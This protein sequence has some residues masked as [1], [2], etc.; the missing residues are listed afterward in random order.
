MPSKHV[1]SRKT[2]LALAV[3]ALM[4]VLGTG[5]LAAQPVGTASCPFAG[6]ANVA[7]ANGFYVTAYPGTNLAQVTLAFR[8]GVAETYGITLTAHRNSY[9]GPIIG[10]PRTATVDLPATGELRVTFDFGG[11]P[12]TAGDTIAFTQDFAIYGPDGAELFYD[13]GT[14][15]C[16]SGSV[17][18]T[19]GTSPPLGSSPT[20]GVGVAITQLPQ[21]FQT[22]I[23][24]DTVL[25]LDGQ[26]GDHRFQVTASYHTSQAGGL[27]GNGQAMPLAQLGGFHGGLFWFFSQDNP[28]VLFKVVNACAVNGYY[29]VYLSANTNVGYSVTVTDTAFANVAKTYT[30]PDLTAALPVQDGAALASCHG[31]GNGILCRPGLLCCPFPTGG[32]NLCI[33]PTPSG[34]CPALP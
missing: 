10:T 31:C 34:S 6:F 2:G 21:P 4:A 19:V 9:D 8:G 12:V 33:A 17:F 18:Q 20:P 30:N 1:R 3:L 27:A 28:E 11:A 24:S 23:P 25:C 13:G 5:A 29:W 7:W 16:N 32:A 26:P 14:G 22:C 15:Q